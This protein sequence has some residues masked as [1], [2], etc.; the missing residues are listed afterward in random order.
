MCAVECSAFSQPTLH[1]LRV[2]TYRHQTNSDRQ[3]AICRRATPTLQAHSHRHALQYGR[4]R[5]PS[6][7]SS[8]AG[9]SKLWPHRDSTL[10]RWIDGAVHIDALRRLPPGLAIK[11]PVIPS[12][13]GA[14]YG[15][16]VVLATPPTKGLITRLTNLP[17]ACGHVQSRAPPR[18]PPHACASASS[19]RQNRLRR[20]VS[21]STQSRPSAKQA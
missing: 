10:V 6:R 3:S 9:H 5:V 16:D 19:L 4:L 12:E 7:H 11:H 1:L 20:R 13:V 2:D 15:K 14:D 17:P 8:L 21:V 18:T